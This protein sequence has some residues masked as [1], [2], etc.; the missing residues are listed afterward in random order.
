MR[1]VAGKHR[2]RR[3]EVPPGA[4]IRPTSD[5]TRQALFN[6]LAHAPWAEAPVLDGVRVL[7][8]FCGSGALGLEALSRGAATVAFLDAAP[9]A[10]E[11]ARR[12][13]AALGEAPPRVDF[14]RADALKPPPARHPAALAFLDPPYAKGLIEPALEALR[15]AGWLAPG[16]VI[17]AE[18]D[19][20]DAVSLPAGFES[21]D[22]R[23]Y[24]HTA[25]RIW[26][27]APSR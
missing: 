14:V 16:A 9:A 20:R 6:I 24:G 2:G 17:V 7:D 21:L 4:A 22:E 25:V 8:V 26:R 27:L 23:A 1:I 5:H 19:A 13:A 12:N 10:L 18:S 15:A 3:I 11:C